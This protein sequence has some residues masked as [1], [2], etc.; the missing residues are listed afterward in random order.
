[1]NDALPLDPA[2]E[3]IIGLVGPIGVDLDLVTSSLSDALRDVDYSPQTL[4]ITQLMREVPTGITIQESP[5]IASFRSRIAYANRVC[6]LLERSD[7]MAILA[8]SAIREMRREE[9]GNPEQPIPNRA[10]II[11]QFKRPQRLSSSGASTESSSSKSQHTHRS[12]FELTE[13]PR[14][15]GCQEAVSLMTLR[16]SRNHTN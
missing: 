2:P 16:Q 15:N 1:M 10:Y 14:K 3:L 9:T 4:R 11:R 5:Y 13:L 6:E 8:I 12:S 7:A